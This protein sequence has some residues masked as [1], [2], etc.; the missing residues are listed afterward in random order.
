MNRFAALLSVLALIGAQGSKVAACACAPCPLEAGG[1]CE[2]APPPCCEEPEPEESCSCSHFDAPEA[3]P[4]DVVLT[5]GAAVVDEAVPPVADP[6]FTGQVAAVTPH[7]PDPPPP[8][9]S[10]YLRDLTLRL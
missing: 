3:V 2:A 4:P 6:D 10:I 8:R 9:H 1:A 5:E 7:G